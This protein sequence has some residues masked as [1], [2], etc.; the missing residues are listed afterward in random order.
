MTKNTQTQ[1]APAVDLDAP[2]F[3][4]VTAEPDGA[5]WAT[6]TALVILSRMLVPMIGRLFTPS[7]EDEQ[8]CPLTSPARLR[9]NELLDATDALTMFGPVGGTALLAV[10]E[11]LCGAEETRKRL[12]LHDEVTEE[13]SEIT[14]QFACEMA[15][16]QAQGRFIPQPVNDN[17]DGSVF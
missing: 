9:F 17:D 16:Y 13:L 5:R 11:A 14:A 3:T 2:L 4:R 10:F 7:S 6:D 8:V 15:T 12:G 1:A